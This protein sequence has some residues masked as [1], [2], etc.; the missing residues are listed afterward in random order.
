MKQ[1]LSRLKWKSGFPLNLLARVPVIGSPGVQGGSTAKLGIM[2][3][4][5]TLQRTLSVA[6]GAAAK[7]VW[8]SFEHL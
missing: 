2:S 1:R 7:V 5:S 8:K 3:S 4:S 6:D